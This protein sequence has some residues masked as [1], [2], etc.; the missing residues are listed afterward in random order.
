L[1]DSYYQVTGQ[2]N[3]KAVEP[4]EEIITE[5]SGPKDEAGQPMMPLSTEGEKPASTGAGSDPAST[6]ANP[7]TAVTPVNSVVPTAPEPQ[8]AP[9]PAAPSPAKEPEEVKLITELPEVAVSGR[10]WLRKLPDD[11]FVLVHKTFRRVK[12]AQAFIRGKEYL[13]NARIAPVYQE[14][15]D[16]ARFAVVTGYFRSKER[17]SN[18]IS[19]LGLPSEVAIV[20]TAKAV[21]QSQ[22]KKPKP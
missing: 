11:S 3:P 10:Q 16:E 18:T 14:G 12:D 9:S 13:V 8:P 19:R 15:K 17:A 2:K 22:L 7:S 4:K 6:P 21:S 5:T 20:P 1:E